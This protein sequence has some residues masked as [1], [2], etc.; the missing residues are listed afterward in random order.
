M[1]SKFGRGG[2]I[3]AAIAG[4]AMFSG[5]A[6][7]ENR[8][9]LSNEAESK[10]SQLE[11]IAKQRGID[12][13]VTEGY[14]SQQRQEQLYAQ[15]RTSPGKIVTW[16]KQSKHTTRNAFDVAVIKGGNITWD[17]KQYEA[18]G[19]AGKSVGLTWGGDWIK[20][21]RPHFQISGLMSTPERIRSLTDYISGLT[22]SD[23]VYRKNV[24]DILFETAVHES[25][26]F[27][28]NEQKWGLGKASSYFQIEASTAEYLVKWSAKHQKAMNLLMKTSGKTR[29]ELLSMSKENIAKLVSENE[30]FAAAVA[31]TKYMSAPGRIPSDVAG[32]AA[33]WSK[34][35]QG[36]SNPTKTSQYLQ[37][38]YKMAA[39]LKATALSSV[40][41]RHVAKP[42]MNHGVGIRAHQ[43]KVGHSI[44]S[45]KAKLSVMQKVLKSVR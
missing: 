45:Q 7:A 39:E 26:G 19:E 28:Y 40:A 1:I 32:R 6:G 43:S 12:F 42:P 13:K 44:K 27:K 20:R 5:I 18:I 14:R 23:P 4:S 10:L 24:S 36:T 37:A 33:Y 17:P 35:Y 38:N 34:Y 41:K 30:K 2:L 22:E 25:G 21:D 8:Y 29:N 16:T 3:A 31:R 15:G 11:A 9:G